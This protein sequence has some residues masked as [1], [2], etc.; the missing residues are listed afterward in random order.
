M[1][2][3]ICTQC[4]AADA[5]DIDAASGPGV[6]RTLL[7]SGTQR[8]LLFK[9]KGIQYLRRDD[10]NQVLLKLCFFA[11]LLYQINFGLEYQDLHSVE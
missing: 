6:V 10:D 2:A 11:V 5:P 3:S 9:F 7:S 8:S 4:Q 1:D